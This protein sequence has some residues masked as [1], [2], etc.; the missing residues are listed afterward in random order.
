MRTHDQGFEQFWLHINGIMSPFMSSIQFCFGNG[1]GIPFFFHLVSMPVLLVWMKQQ[2]PKI[3]EKTAGS[4][5][6]G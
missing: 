4:I 1:P 6:P 3:P 2:Q 5:N